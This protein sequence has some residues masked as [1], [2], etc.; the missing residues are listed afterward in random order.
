ML[1]MDSNDSEECVDLVQEVY[2]YLMEGTYPDNVKHNR[3]RVIQEK[4]QHFMVQEG[5]LYYMQEKKV[6]RKDAFIPVHDWFFCMNM[7][8][9][10]EFSTS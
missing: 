4:A 2:R 10:N 3:G 1:S 9:F 6:R 7:L 8:R 5:E